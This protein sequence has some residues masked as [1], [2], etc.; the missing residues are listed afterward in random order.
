LC[1]KSGNIRYLI[2][3]QALRSGVVER[4]FLAGMD[5]LNSDTKTPLVL[6]GNKGREEFGREVLSRRAE[7][8]GRET[9]F[10]ASTRMPIRRGADR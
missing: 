7:S 9:K 1:P 3:R 5:A 2:V 6:V 8:L 4:R 10:Y